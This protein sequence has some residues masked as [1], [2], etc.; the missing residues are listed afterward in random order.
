MSR[1]IPGDDLAA[2]AVLATDLGDEKERHA[3]QVAEMGGDLDDIDDFDA[4]GLDDGSVLPED[5]DPLNPAPAASQ[6]DEETEEEATDEEADDEVVEDAPDAEAEEEPEAEAEAEESDDEEEPAKP[7]KGIPKWRFDEVNESRKAAEEKLARLE[8]QLE[9]GKPPEEAEE[10]YN[11]RDNEK[12]YMDL[13]LDGDTEAALA[14]REEIDAAKYASWKSE[15]QTA[16]KTELSSEAETQELVA[17]SKEAEQMFDVFN[18]DSDNY[19]QPMLDKVMVFMRGYEGTMGRGDAFVAALADVVEMYDLMPP[20]E[21]DA[22]AA[23]TPTGKAKVD[24]KKAKL[25]AQAH[26]PVGNQ[27][28]A[29]ADTG[30]VAP[31]IDDMSDEELDALPEKTLARMRGDIL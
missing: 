6:S 16:T 11:I 15:T 29:S 4:S 22:P 31:S 17:M 1:D 24:P 27:G 10:A 9:A 12:E 23:G 21:G 30:A 5:Y 14:K 19:N 26:Q 2:D 25:K 28:G 13:L 18:P 7:P 8:A 20:E 3:A